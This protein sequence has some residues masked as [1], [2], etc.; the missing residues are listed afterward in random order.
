MTLQVR[1]V[2]RPLKL[3]HFDIENRPSTYWY[4][5]TATAEVT[6][7]GWSWSGE[8]AVHTALLEPDA[9]DESTSLMLRRFKNAYDRADVVTGHYIRKHDLPILNSAMLLNR[10]PRLGSKL[11]IDTQVDLR[12]HGGLSFSQESIAAMFRLKAEKHHMTQQMWRD[13]N[14]LQDLTGVRERV[15]LDV[16]QHKEVFWEL[17]CADF[18]KPA[19]MWYS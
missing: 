17:T 9:L 19:R 4:D 10:L 11:V 15:V 13:S 2:D 5:G 3:L 14:R 8:E 1:L 12:K 7:I 6:A 16:I 18:L